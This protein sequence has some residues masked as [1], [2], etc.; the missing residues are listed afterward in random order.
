MQFAELTTFPLNEDTAPRQY[1]LANQL[2]HFSPEP[3][4]LQTLLESAQLLG[5]DDPA[6]RAIR[7]QFKAAYPQAFDQ[8]MQK[9]AP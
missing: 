1:T 6:L 7:Q 2:L 3:R 9:H 4:V 8:W 5:L